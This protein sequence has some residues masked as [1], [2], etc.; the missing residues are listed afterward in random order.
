[1]EGSAIMRSTPA[2]RVTLG[3]KE[4]L[5]S[6]SRA[7]VVESKGPGIT[8]DSLLWVDLLVSGSLT[9]WERKDTYKPIVFISSTLGTGKNMTEPGG[10]YDIR[11]KDRE[12]KV[13]SYNNVET[14]TKVSL[15][16][17]VYPPMK[18]DCEFKIGFQGPELYE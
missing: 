11:L 16:C 17:R 15:C 4:Y 9:L 13:Q 6:M 12:G 10:T 5:K 8:L 2:V 18:V 1:M 7:P 3:R 14:V